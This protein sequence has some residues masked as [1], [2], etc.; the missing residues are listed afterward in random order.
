MTLDT[1]DFDRKMGVLMSAVIPA[2]MRKGLAKA[3][4]AL[5][6]DTIMDLPS[7]P[8]LTSAL[9]GSG[10]VFV[11]MKKVDNSSRHKFEGAADFQPL[12]A[13]AENKGMV[14]DIVFNAPY[15]ARWHENLPSSGKFSY[16]GA[17][18]KYMEVKMVEGA[19]KYM[20]IIAQEVRV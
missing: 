16:E 14:A 1:R 9:R 11:N 3:G 12:T 18:I 20:E 15:A 19:M 7:T 5:M 13:E 4:S 17:G 2:K 10:A 6:E 8:L